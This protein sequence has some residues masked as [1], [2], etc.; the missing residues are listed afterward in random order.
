M[1]F[2]GSTT[3]PATEGKLLPNARLNEI[4]REILPVPA[5]SAFESGE[6]V[7]FD[8]ASPLGNCHVLARQ[9][10]GVIEMQITPAFL[11]APAMVTLDKPV[12]A[13]TPPV[14]GTPPVAPVPPTP[15]ASV[16]SPASAVPPAPINDS[17]QKDAVLPPEIR[18]FNWGGLFLSWIWAIGNNTWVGLLGLIP[19]IG[20]I[21]RLVLGFGGNQM[22]W[23]ARR[24]ESVAHFQKTQKTWG[25]AGA[26]I[27]LGGNLFMIPLMAA[28]LFPVFARARENARR[29]SCQQNMKR[30]MLAAYQYQQANGKFPT[31]T[32]MAAWKTALMPYARDEKLFLCPSTQAGEESYTLN[33]LMSGVNPETLNDPAG[34]PVFFD[35][36]T[37]HLEGA[38]VAF[39]DGHIKFFRQN[40]LPPSLQQNATK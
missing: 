39:A 28:I 22:A 1:Q 12:D 31:G 27:F 3:Q 26:A 14:T 37:R 32:T 2:E 9:T 7:H 15:P 29:S 4:L 17:G 19:C 11:T 25:I 18:G 23:R 36:D 30:V 33:P 40:N 8:Y 10:Q 24:W 16:I 6:P 35:S 5:L 34:T 13:P 21:M 20:F 38:S